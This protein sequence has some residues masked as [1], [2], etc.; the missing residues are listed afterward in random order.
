MSSQR[1]LLIWVLGAVSATAFLLGVLVWQHQ[2]TRRHWSAFVLGNPHVGAQVFERKGCIQCHAVSGWGSNLAPDL[3]L[4]RPP[5]SSLNQL[6]SAMWN[7][8]PR[9]WARIRAERISYPVLN[10]EDMAHLFAFLY[11]ARYVDEPGDVSRGRQ[12][13]QRKSCGRCHSLRGEQGK[14]GADLS[15]VGGV[16]T[17]I[18]WAQLMWNHAPAMEAGME[19]LGL[20]WPRFESDEMNDLLAY[21]REVTTGPRRESALLPADPERGRELFRSKSCIR[22]HE[23]KGEGGRVGPELGPRRKLPPTLVRFAGSM[24]NHSPQMFQEMKANGIARPSFEGR[25]MAD[26]IAFLYSLRYFEPMGSPEDGQNLFASRGCS[27]CHGARG[28]GSPKGPT[29]RKRDEVFTSINL[30]TGLW[31]HGPQMYKRTQQVGIPW[32]TLKETDVSDLVA[33]LSASLEENP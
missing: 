15:A 16:D 27:Q 5:R 20:S 9:M 11:T 24:W 13:F 26:L 6:V 22:C 21:I 8:A 18:V 2:R 4:E 25:E 30:A 29:L 1:Q 7:C 17:P 31:A 33:F 12:L 3:G 10:Q 19:Q 14:L 32:P 23:V 28:E